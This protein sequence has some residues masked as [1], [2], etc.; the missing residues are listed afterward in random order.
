MVNRVQNNKKYDIVFLDWDTKKFKR[1]S[2][3]IYLYEEIDNRDID[4]IKENIM[5]EE[6]EFITI[7]NCGNNIGN[8]IAISHFAGAFL[9]DV[10]VQFIKKIKE[11][12]KNEK[13]ENIK[14]QNNF[15]YDKSL[16]DIVNNAFKD[17]RFIVDPKLSNG[18]EV[19]TE[20]VINA[21]NQK[22]KYF[23]CYKTEK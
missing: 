11:E 15:S 19:Y 13:N 2:A 16:V 20:W 7:Q 12:N 21:F 9:A 23:C 10:N 1:K 6:Y 18:N 4:H 22:D 5:K 17:S 8:N 3:K 14:I